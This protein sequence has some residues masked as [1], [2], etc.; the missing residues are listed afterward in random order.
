MQSLVEENNT[1]QTNAYSYGSFFRKNRLIKMIQ[2]LTAWF[3]PIKSQKQDKIESMLFIQHIPTPLP[4][5]TTL[6]F[7]DSNKQ[8]SILYLN[9][10]EQEVAQLIFQSVGSPFNLLPYHTYI[11]ELKNYQVSTNLIREEELKYEVQLQTNDKKGLHALAE[12]LKKSE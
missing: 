12:A 4:I 8:I 11:S 5:K 7:L 9:T 3:I 6:L 1:L 10:Q 2:Q